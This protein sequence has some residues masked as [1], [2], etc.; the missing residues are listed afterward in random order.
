MMQATE[1]R[2]G[3]YININGEDVNIGYGVIMDLAQKNKGIKNDYLCSLTFKPIQLTEQWLLDFGFNYHQDDNS[4]TL[5]GLRIY[6]YEGVNIKYL[7]QSLFEIINYPVHKLQNLYHA[8]TGKEL[9]KN[10][11]NEKI[12]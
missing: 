6:F 7:G 12:T 1:L 8:L 4:Y 2:I 9:T 3:N 10:K 5:R 11:S